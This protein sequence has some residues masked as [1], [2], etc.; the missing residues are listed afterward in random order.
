M[1]IIR[2]PTTGRD[3]SDEV[4]KDHIMDG[5]PCVPAMHCSKVLISLFQFGLTPLPVLCYLGTDTGL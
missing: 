1:V 3:D 5:K 4:G 2:V